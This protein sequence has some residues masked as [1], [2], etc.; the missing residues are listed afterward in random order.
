MSTRQFLFI[1]FCAVLLVSSLRADGVA[2]L[3]GQNSNA[4]GVAVFGISPLV[5]LSTFTAGDGAFEVL[6]LPD[7]SKYYVI[8]KSGTNTIMS[9]DNN[10]LN[11]KLVASLETVATGAALSSNGTRLVV[12][13]GTLHI[14]DTSKDQDLVPG[15][16]NTGTTVYDVALSLDGKFAYALGQTASGG[17]QL[18]AIS[19][20]DNSTVGLPQYGVLGSATG[21]TVGFNGLI[22]ISTQNQIIELNPTTLQPTAAGVIGVNALP[23]KLVFTPDGKYALAVNQTPITGSSILLINLASRTIANIVPDNGLTFDTLLVTGE[24]PNTSTTNFLAYSSASQT[25]VQGGIGTSGN[26]ACCSAPTDGGVSSTFVT[27]VA[28]SDELPFPGNETAHYLFI[29]TAG[30]LYRVDLT[31]GPQ[32]TGQTPLPNQSIGALQYVAL[33]STNPSEVLLAYGDQQTVAPNGTSQPLVVRSLDTAGRP[34]SGATITFTASPNTASLSTTTAT[35]GA[36]GFAETVLTAPPTAGRVVVSATDGK[37]PYGFTITVGSVTLPN[38]GNLSIVAGQGQV[39][40]SNVNTDEP[41]T[42]SPLTVLLTDVNGKPINGSPVTFTINNPAL[43]TLGTGIGIIGAGSVIVQTN[44]Q[45]QASANFGTTNVPPGLGSQ[46]AQITVKGNGTNAVTFYVT[47]YT[48]TPTCELGQPNVEFITPQVGTVLAGGA[49]T[50]IPAAFSALVVDSTGMPLANVGVHTCLPLPGVGANPATCNPP[51]A[52]APVPFGTC[53]DPTGLGVLSNAQ[54]KVTCDLVLNGSWEGE[55]LARSTAMRSLPRAS[56]WTLRPDHPASSKSSAVT[57]NP[58][59]LAN[60]CRLLCW[61][62]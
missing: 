20:A 36:N 9:V 45:G 60:N 53:N 52:N 42:G 6:A 62:K 13:A 48:C 11:P 39:L 19:L 4:P 30:T 8:S 32:I 17:T 41:N 44:S 50:T 24:N 28:I 55:P 3:P 59:S 56:H 2:T 15:G 26:F 51:T 5:S 14:F 34:V 18:N 16:I 40:P 61:R 57:T 25:L 35:T 27:G 12:A 43:G 29:A 23:G 37:H 49:G 10:F 7:G 1:A 54:G 22:Y 38:S 33:P 58:E 46:Q 47:T 21:V 31:L